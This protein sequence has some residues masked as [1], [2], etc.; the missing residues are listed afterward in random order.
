MISAGILFSYYDCDIDSSFTFK[1]LLLIIFYGEIFFLFGFSIILDKLF[2][3][4]KY[5]L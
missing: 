4:V 2:Q 3:L 5:P 1:K